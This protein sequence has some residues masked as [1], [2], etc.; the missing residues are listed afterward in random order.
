MQATC[1]EVHSRT[2]AG[3]QFA[4]LD[5][6]ER[7]E[8]DYVHI[9]GALFI[10]M[11]ELQSRV[12]ELDDYRERELIV[13]CHHG[14]RSLRVATWL[15]QQGFTSARSLSGGIDQWSQE[16]DPSLPRY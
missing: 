11:S 4:L 1:A 10:P 6:R 5:C 8:Y 16:I 15:A 14:V 3:E 13:Y 7:D 2:S 9:A 12:A